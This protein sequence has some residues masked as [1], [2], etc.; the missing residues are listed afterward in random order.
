METIELK[1]VANADKLLRTTPPDDH[2][3]RLIKHDS[4]LVIG[5]ECV[6]IYVNLDTD[7]LK[8]MKRVAR[9][10]KL[11]FSHR[12]NSGVPTA[13]SVFGAVPRSP[14]RKDFCRFSRISANEPRNFATAFNY[15]ERIA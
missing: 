7:C 5:G 15:S 2:G 6:G 1:Q 8:E 3:S 13:S 12:F 10:T 4:K 9:T 14:F 11:S